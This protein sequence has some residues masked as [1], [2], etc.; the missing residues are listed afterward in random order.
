MSFKI[1]GKAKYINIGTGFWGI[2]DNNGKEYLPVNMPEQ[3]K[4]DGE[5]VECRAKKS[6]AMN[7]HMWGEPISIISFETVNP[8]KD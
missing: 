8:D 7:I 1:E 6:D 2:I 5:N 3:L 4:F